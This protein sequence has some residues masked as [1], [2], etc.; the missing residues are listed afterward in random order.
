MKSKNSSKS[1]YCLCMERRLSEFDNNQTGMRKEL[2]PPSAQGHPLTQA[3][4]TSYPA[5]S[6]PCM[7]AT[8]HNKVV[9]L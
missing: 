8:M 3:Y 2:S 7:H 1:L 9:P 4:Y 5:H 6:A